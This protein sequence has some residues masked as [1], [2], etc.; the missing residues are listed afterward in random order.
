MKQMLHIE[1]IMDERKQK[2]GLWWFNLQNKLL[3]SGLC[4]KITCETMAKPMDM[5]LCGVKH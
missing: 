1:E 3:V 4:R 5:D 2:H